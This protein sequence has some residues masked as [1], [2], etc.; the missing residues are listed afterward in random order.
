M[1][2]TNERF[3]DEVLNLLRFAGHTN[4]TMPIYINH[5]FKQV[6]YFDTNKLLSTDAALSGLDITAINI[7]HL[8]NLGNE[9]FESEFPDKKIG[10]YSVEIVSSIE[11]RSQAAYDI[12][13]LLHPTFD[14]S[15]TVMIFC[16]NDKFML[17][18]TKS[19]EDIV[20][21]DWYDRY[22][23][24]D[25]IAEMIDISDFSFD[26]I[27][28]FISEFIYK[29]ARNYY[30][31]PTPT[32]LEIYDYLPV[33]QSNI[34]FET[35]EK[36]EIKEFVYD[37]MNKSQSEYG[38]D[39]VAPCN[40]SDVNYNRIYDELETLSLDLEID[41]E[42]PETLFDEDELFDDDKLENEDDQ[43]YI[44]D[45]DDNDLHDIP[46]EVI[47]NPILLVKWLNNKG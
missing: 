14:E 12:H 33:Y 4:A 30:L 5:T 17:S 8:F 43:I 11:D 21:S 28:D 20:L 26:S 39:Y 41:E 29:I 32:G 27:S 18:I 19:N 23:D 15:D 35:W 13:R 6:V 3:Y 38:Y 16:H 22:S 46:S 37:L 45:L 34:I 25:K 7:S 47:N 42:I 1:I 2:Q 24:V 40:I 44:E 36:D 31:Y 9:L 10:Y